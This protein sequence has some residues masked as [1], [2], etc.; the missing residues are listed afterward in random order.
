MKQKETI[1]RAGSKPAARTIFTEENE[2]FRN[3][4]TEFAQNSGASKPS[5][6]KFPETISHRDSSAKIYDKR[7]G[8]DYYR[9]SYKVSGRRVL[10]TF[11]DYGKAKAEAERLVRE[12]SSGSAA[13]ALSSTQA[14][15]A[16]AVN[17]HLENFFRETGRRVSALEAVSQFTAASKVLGERILG[18][19]V[20]SYLA[21]TE[22]ILSAT[23]GQAVEKF[24]AV[25]SIKTVPRDG[26]R[27]ELSPKYAYNRAIQLRRFV[28]TFPNTDLL[29]LNKQHIQF[30]VE[31]LSG[32]S[33]KSR[34]HYR[35]SLVQFFDWCVGQDF[36]SKDHLL[37][38]PLTRGREKANDST[39]D[40]YTS[41]EFAALL[42][43]SD[44]SMRAMV[45]IAGLAGLRASELLRLDW[46]D[47]WRVKN[48]IDVTAQ[49]AKTRKRRKV[50]I[51]ES[52]AKW[53]QPFSEA[54]GSVWTGTE[55]SYQR[56]FFALCSRLKIERKPNGL[57]H[58]FATYFYALH[59][60][61][62]LTAKQCGNSPAMIFA[63]YS[64][65]ATKDEG[66]AWFAVAPE[67]AE[68]LVESPTPATP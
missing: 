18:D 12:L 45:A 8:F 61:E 13:A 65:A 43:S 19:C 37:S 58:G 53:L 62:N 11:A 17:E 46:S 2:V 23:I 59:S 6:V 40:R 68:I 42:R 1:Q 3:S 14:S 52:L 15:D 21:M 50:E 47:V 28:G 30:F 44:G 38:G 32:F 20:K 41:G 66:L 64:D 67:P 7:P 56:E 39:I 16:L 36:L 5:K 54:S 51:C 24:L 31:S 22:N 34:N 60:D 27:P 35:T 4:C 49:K 33:P 48:H 63:H 25:E 26:K 29:A 57:R 10:K 9:L 55:R